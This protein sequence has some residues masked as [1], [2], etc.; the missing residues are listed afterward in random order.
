MV[1]FWKLRTELRMLGLADLLKIAAMQTEHNCILN[2]SGACQFYFKHKGFGFCVLEL[3][4]QKCQAE[5]AREKGQR[6]ETLITQA[7]AKNGN[8]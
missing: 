2:P 8:K 7:Q 4:G 3:S 6:A 5:K 1:D